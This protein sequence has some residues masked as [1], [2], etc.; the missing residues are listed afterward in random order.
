MVLVPMS[1]TKQ[2]LVSYGE[3]STIDQCL[4]DLYRFRDELNA[5]LDFLKRKAEAAATKH[6][7]RCKEA[8]DT[9]ERVLVKEKKIPTHRN[10]CIHY[11]QDFRVLYTHGR[12]HHE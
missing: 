6:N 9:I 10:W 1:V 3:N 4:D 7:K 5:E 8:W 2:K 11:D 12:P